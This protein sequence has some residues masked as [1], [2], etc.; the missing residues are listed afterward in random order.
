MSAP[1]LNGQGKLEELV[2]SLADE[3]N[4]FDV[5]VQRLLTAHPTYN[6]LRDERYLGAVKEA[7]AEIRDG[8]ESGTHPEG[9]RR[10]NFTLVRWLKAC[11]PAECHE[12]NSGIALV[13]LA[14]LLRDRILGEGLLDQVQPEIIWSD[15]DAVVADFEDAWAKCRYARGDKLV[16]LCWRRACESPVRQAP[17]GRYERF[18]S[19]AYYLQLDQGKKEI[20]LPVNDDLADIMGTTK[21]TVSSLVNKAVR[22]GYLTIVSEKYDHLRGRART[23]KAD[24]EKLGIRRQA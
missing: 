14:I 7:L 23:F 11:L 18:L 6:C 21:M 9:D 12:G 2:A 3:Y 1:S 13:P 19:L 24:I 4:T 22:E 15:D 8:I 5:S 17:N 20:M 16:A 10:W